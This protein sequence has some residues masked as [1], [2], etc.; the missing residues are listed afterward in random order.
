VN[1]WLLREIETG[2]TKLLCLGLDGQPAAELIEG[3]IGVW[4]EAITAGRALA[5]ED[6]PRIRAGFA[7]VVTRSRRWP[8]PAEFLEAMPKREAASVTALPV[9][10]EE[11][12]RRDAA[13]RAALARIGAA[14][15]GD[16]RIVSS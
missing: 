3:T 4:Y 16:G 13:A 6:A 1:D 8:S 10:S 9:G 2:I 5:V 15:D 11:R 7:T 12:A 14:L